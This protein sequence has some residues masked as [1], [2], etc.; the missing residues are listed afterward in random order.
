MSEYEVI[1][2]FIQPVR[3]KVEAETAGEAYDVG[4]E[5]L[6]NGEGIDMEGIWQREF[7]VYD[8]DGDEVPEHELYELGN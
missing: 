3:I 5:K 6:R 7:T 2:Y 8:K 1:G 4:E